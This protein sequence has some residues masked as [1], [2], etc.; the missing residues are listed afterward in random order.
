MNNEIMGHVSCK[1]TTTAFQK[2]SVQILGTL[3]GCSEDWQTMGENLGS[4][5]PRH[6]IQQSERQD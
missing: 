2:E 3:T 5:R 4:Y 1:K 6:K